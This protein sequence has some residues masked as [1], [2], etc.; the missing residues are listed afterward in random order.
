MRGGRATSAEGQQGEGRRAGDLSSKVSPARAAAFEILRRVETEGAFASVLLAS[1]VEELSHQDRALCHEMVLGTL[2]RQLWLDHLIGYYARRSAE[3]LD[4]PVRLVLRLGL[5]Q[6]RFLSRIPASAAVNESVKLVRLARVRSADSFVNAVLRRATREPGYDPATL[7]ADPLE[8]VSIETSHPRWLIERWSNLF[9]LEETLLFAR[10]NN[11][12]PPVAFRIAGERGVGPYVAEELS[13]AGGVLEASRIATG[14]WR[15]KGASERLREL[16]REGLVYL[17][18]EA[19]QAVAQALE[20]RAGESVLDA[21]AA[22]GSKTTHI[23][24]RAETLALLV[25]GDL[26]EHRLR[27]LL[28]TSARLKVQGVRPVA[29]DAESALPFRSG[30]FDRALVDVPCT[31]T[32]TL[33]RNPEIRWRISPSDI[34]ELSDR[35]KRIL[36]NTSELVR[37]GGR[38]VYSTCSV[39]P[40]ENERVVELFLRE[41]P[42][43]KQISL[44]LPDAWQEAGGGTRTWPQRCGADGFFIAAF[45]R[46][47]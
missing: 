15:I 34:K 33:R 35:Q 18:D 21:C 27:T 11:E 26:Y 36:C 23:A 3:K 39:E 9:G 13:A 28:E 47:S 4:A 10:S 40:E 42:C 19:S 14:A 32:G 7:V 43:F 25:A 6:L 16:A 31:G 8:R 24:A 29:Y 22:P 17:Q 37:S 38:L 44:R 2:R 30:S 20:A 45:E 5:Y 12:A 46:L 41:Q 1:S